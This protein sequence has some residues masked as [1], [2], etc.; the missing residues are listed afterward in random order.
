MTCAG[1]GAE[2]V[3][4]GGSSAMLVVSRVSRLNLLE[5]MKSPEMKATPSSPTLADAS[6]PLL[7]TAASEREAEAT[8]TARRLDTGL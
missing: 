2:D 5:I 7:L 1:I 4:E 8:D 6:D 3:G